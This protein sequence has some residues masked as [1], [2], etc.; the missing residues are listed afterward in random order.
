MEKKDLEYIADRYEK[1]IRHRGIMQGGLIHR[2]FD[3]SVEVKECDDDVEHYNFVANIDIELHGNK[4]NLKRY[5]YFE[6]SEGYKSI[7]LGEVNIEI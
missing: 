5:G 4:Y 6:A 7:F 2:D 3:V 1:E